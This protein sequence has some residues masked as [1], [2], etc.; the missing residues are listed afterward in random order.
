MAIVDIV[1][2]SKE[3]PVKASIYIGT[4]FT[5]GTLYKTN[6]KERDYDQAVTES[7]HEMLLIGKDIRNPHTDLYLSS[8]LEAKRDRRLRYIS[9]FFFSL[10]YFDTSS[11]D[12]GIFESRCNLVKP[13]WTEFHK[14]IADVGVFGRF[15][16]L[17][18]AMVDFDVNTD[19]WTED[20]RPRN[21][22]QISHVTKLYW[23][24]ISCVLWIMHYLP[25]NF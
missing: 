14:Q 10:V 1:K 2:D 9:L 18:K 6:P 20:G 21:P 22:V 12:S 15:I 8:I 19:E 4:L 25:L 13:H 16:Y 17:D 7:A 3:S 23:I 11:H 24:K 5:L